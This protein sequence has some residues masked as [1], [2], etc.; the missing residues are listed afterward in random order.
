MFSYDVLF[1]FRAYNDIDNIVPVIYKLKSCSKNLAIKSII[2]SAKYE[3]RNNYLIRYLKSIGVPVNHIF[4]YSYIG[5]TIF[6]IYFN[7]SKKVKELR[8]FVL[9]RKFIV[10]FILNRIDEKL[11]SIECDIN[12]YK[13]IKKVF[14]NKRNGIVVFDHKFTEEYNQ[15]C[16]SAKKRGLTSIALPHGVSLGI[17]ESHTHPIIGNRKP[18]FDYIVFSSGQEAKRFFGA[19]YNQKK[20]V[21]I[22]GSARF[23]IEWISQLRTFLPQIDLP[24]KNN[25]IKIALMMSKP[26]TLKQDK[27]DETI[28]ML[29]QIKEVCLLLKPHT[30]GMQYRS[31]LPDNVHIV[32]NNTPS[33]NIIDWADVTLFTTSSIIFENILLDKPVL[34]LKYAVPHRDLIFERYVKTWS[35]KN[36]NELEKRINKFIQKKNVRTY[37]EEER[38]LLIKNY[39]EPEGNDVL[40][41]Y[42]RFLLDCLINS[43]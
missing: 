26:K 40:G 21:K 25:S 17:E 39:L 7:F 13:I 15:F 43:K 27:I 35:V 4:H 10:R 34:F 31:Y 37:T 28:A 11:N 2:Y 24:S 23:S 33:S 6:R 16:K 14:G 22:F 18:F 8:R 29:G 41:N 19:N 30:R 5:E 9:L 1:C 3:A 12:S 32:D 38:K 20:Y 36:I 42:S